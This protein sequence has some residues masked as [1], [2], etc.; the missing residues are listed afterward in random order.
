MKCFRIIINTLSDNIA[1][2]SKESAQRMRIISSF[3]LEAKKTNHGVCVIS[4][5]KTINVTCVYTFIWLKCYRTL[6]SIHFPG[7]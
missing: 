7:A 5:R 4:T 1:L 2:K 3:L 6:I